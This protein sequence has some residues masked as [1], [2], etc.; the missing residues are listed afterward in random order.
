[1]EHSINEISADLILKGGSVS[2]KPSIEELREKYYGE[3]KK[4]IAYPS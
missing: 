4:Y 2:F 3:I 1:M